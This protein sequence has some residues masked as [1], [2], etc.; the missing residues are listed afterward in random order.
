M[1]T[2]VHIVDSGCLHHREGGRRQ[3]G[4]QDYEDG[5]VACNAAVLDL[6]HVPLE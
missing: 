4:S 3:Y 1:D 6:E 5:H 2:V